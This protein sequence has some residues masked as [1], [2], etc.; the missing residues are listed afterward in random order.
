MNNPGILT[1]LSEQY[2]AMLGKP[3][4][5]HQV[6]DSLPVPI[7][8][9]A[10]D[11]MTIF[12]NYA[13]MELHNLQD[14][15]LVVGKYNFNDDPVCLEIMGQEVYDRVSRGEAVTFP[16]FPAPIR[17]V[18]R[19]GVVEEKPYEALTM[20]LFFQPSGTTARSC[21]RFCSIP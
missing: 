7:Q 15:G 18:V 9:F 21:A 11:G 2:R 6:F 20:D 19:R 5:T 1:G 4:L 12:V 14:A 17:D 13:H 16:N 8:I 10:P 3:E